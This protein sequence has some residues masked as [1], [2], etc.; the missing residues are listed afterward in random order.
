MNQTQQNCTEIINNTII[1]CIQIVNK[2]TNEIFEE[3]NEER[4]KALTIF[5]YILLSILCILLCLGV[6]V[7]IVI[8]C[9]MAKKCEYITK[10]FFSYDENNINNTNSINKFNFVKER[11]NSII[12]SVFKGNQ[13]VFDCSICLSTINVGEEYSITSCKHKFHT[14]CLDRWYIEQA[15]VPYVDKK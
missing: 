10:F 8:F 3:E 2:S 6:S 12:K 7:S 11:F 4:N 13:E 9:D 5:S 1:N 15:R 14:H